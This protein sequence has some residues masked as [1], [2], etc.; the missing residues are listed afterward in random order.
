VIAVNEELKKQVENLQYDLVAS[1]L[2]RLDTELF[3]K[4]ASSANE[5]GL[6]VCKSFYDLI[7][8]VQEMHHNLL[9]NEKVLNQQR[10]ELLSIAEI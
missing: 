9:L 1:N 2:S 4:E 7:G 5:K 3:M 6:M 10:E 8:S